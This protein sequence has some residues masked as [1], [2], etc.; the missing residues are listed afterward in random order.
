MINFT[1][2][3][4]DFENKPFTLTKANEGEEMFITKFN[5]EETMK[6]YRQ[7]LETIDIYNRKS[8]LPMNE[9]ECLN[10]NYN[11]IKALL[12]NGILPIVKHF[13]GKKYQVLEIAE[14]T[15]N[16]R[17]MVVYQ[18]LYGKGKIWIRPATMFNEFV[19]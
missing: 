4:E 7:V 6:L 12:S 2:N 5:Y 16:K 11:R 8:K 10:E 14:H 13:K 1:I 19:T 3:L 9:K 17:E 15:E 18:A